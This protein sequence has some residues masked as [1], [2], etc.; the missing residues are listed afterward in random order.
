MDSFLRKTGWESIATSIVFAIVGI[1][2]ICNPEGTLSVATTI[3]GISFIAIGIIKII[4]H[5]VD[6]GESDIYNFKLING[7]IAIIIG[8]VVMVNSQ[9][10]GTFFRVFIG[11]WIIYSGIM[12]L[13]F[14]NK[15]RLLGQ[16]SWKVVL[17]ISIAILIFGLFVTFHPGAVGITIGILILIYAIM[18]LI[19]GFIIIKNI[20]NEV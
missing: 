19:E 1:L 16:E 4:N 3:I 20:D 15:L 9:S 2:I 17:V 12:R 7:V 5:F 14:A 10:L 11:I 18:D 13:G 8:I 6:S